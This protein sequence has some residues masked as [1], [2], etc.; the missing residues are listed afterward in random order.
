MN[1]EHS[2]MWQRGRQGGKPCQCWIAVVPLTSER[3]R[4]SALNWNM[5]FIRAFTHGQQFCLGV[6]FNSHFTYVLRF[7]G[8]I[9]VESCLTL[10]DPMD[11]SLPGSSVHGGSPGKNSGMGCHAQ[12]SDIIGKFAFQA[13]WLKCPPSLYYTH[14]SNKSN[15][16]IWSQHNMILPDYTNRR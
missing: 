15:W 6:S 7:L 16:S 8:V 11:G 1:K 13:L 3:R 10:C 14:S 2:R 4:F 5:G 12:I 9:A